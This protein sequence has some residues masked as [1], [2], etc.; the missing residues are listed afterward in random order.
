M[1]SQPSPQ[2]IMIVDDNRDAADLISEF[3][4]M[5]GYEAIPVYSGIEALTVAETFDPNVIFL[6]LGMPKMNGLQVASVLKQTSKFRDVRLIALTAWGDESTRAQTLAI[7]FDHHLV[8]PAD[9]N[10]I[11][12]LLDS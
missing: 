9:L 7:G 12:K 3:L 5:L 8:K 11:L 10:E 4:M 6:D 1:T 2:R